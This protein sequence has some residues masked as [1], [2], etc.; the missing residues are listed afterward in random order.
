M[1]EN[2]RLRFGLMALGMLALVAGLCAGLM[3]IGWSL[4]AESIAMLHGPLM[5]CGFLGTV[6]S[7]E[8]AVALGRPWAFGAP[9]LT[10]LGGLLLVADAIAVPFG[11]ALGL[12]LGALSITSGSLILPAVFLVVWRIQPAPFVA[13]MGAG[14][15]AWCV[16]NVLWLVGI[17]LATV[18]WWWMGF[19]VLTIAGERLEL[20]RVL[21]HAPRIQRMFLGLMG[22][23]GVGLVASSVWPGFGERLLGAVL[24]LVGAWLL[25]YD[26]A[27][28]TVRLHGLTRYIAWCL[29]TGYMWLIGGGVLLAGFGLGSAPF[30]Y[31][32]V[33]HAIF[34][35][36]VFSM[37][38]GHAP[39]IFPSVLQVPLAYRPYFYGHLSLLHASLLL[40]TIADL[41][42]MPGL[43]RWGGMLSAVAIIL[44]LVATVASIVSERRR[45]KQGASHP[46]RRGEFVTIHTTD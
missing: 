2:V 3:R 39:V 38:F 29:I 4:H 13:V 42:S 5:V 30:M 27:R 23:F 43:R 41:A 10:G 40:R 35:G 18:V 17:P 7:M 24:V 8:R 36:F 9:F 15:I 32:A 26:V 46:F 34:V 21:M 16:G 44:F 25:R 37:I 12:S 28:R 20:S 22:L 11:A 19:L 6:I 33:L 1:I 45:M 14:A 31:D